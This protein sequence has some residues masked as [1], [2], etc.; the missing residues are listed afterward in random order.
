[1]NNFFLWLDRHKDVGVLLLRLF[2][3]GRLI[4]G[5]ID[6]VTNWNHMLQFMYFLQEFHFPFPLGSALLS[7]Y[8]QLLAGIL[9]IFGWKVRYVSLVM[10]FNFL[11]AVAVIHRKDRF[12][13]MTPALLIVFCCLL[14]LFQGPGQYSAD[15][16][17]GT[18][19][20]NKPR[21]S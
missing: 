9:F 11:V 5:V 15:Q 3:G 14:F 13:E 19:L 18:H 17:F 21:D 6:N 2:I 20:S 16:Q 12:E 8:A 10:I 4:Y 1:M 7:V